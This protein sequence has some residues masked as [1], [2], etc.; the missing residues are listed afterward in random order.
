[1]PRQEDALRFAD[2]R[3]WLAS[4]SRWEYAA[5]TLWCVILLFCCIR[6]YY[7][8]TR[9]TVY[10]IY[11]SSSRLWWE[12]GELYEPYR[13][14]NEPDGYRYAPGVALLFAPFAL[15]PDAHGGVIWRMVSVATLFGA[16]GWFA[17]AVL[18]TPRTG[19]QFGAWLLLMIPLTLQSVNNGQFNVLVVAALLG[20][21]A[22]IA[23]D[24]W[25][26][27][28][29]LL[30]LAMVGKLYPAALGLVLMLLYPRRLAW[31]VPLACIA[32]VLASFVFQQPDY[33]LDQHR[34]WLASLW[35]DDRTNTIPGHMYRDLWLLIHVY[36]LPISRQAYVLLQV[37]G[38]IMVALVC[39]QRQRRGWPTAALLRSVLALTITWMMLFGP[40][41]ESSSFILLAPPLACSI[42]ASASSVLTS[43][44]VLLW[45]SGSLF[46]VAVVL[47]GLF[48]NLG[49]HEAGMHA[50][51]S[52]LYFTYLLT[53]PSPVSAGVWHL[54]PGG[55]RL[56][57]S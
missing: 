32:L 55:L 8:P 5:A 9:Q 21:V 4:R 49:V 37:V 3:R 51:A 23:Q 35:L 2:F 30:A 56:V 38:G 31:R 1:L 20:A 19:R 24:R 46:L 6:A 11:S 16:L 36:E 33:V 17:R 28:S 41:T 47:G 45:S 40:A 25:N 44:E 39:W 14:L 10:P 29:L 52:L 42:V 50:W 22:A 57:R 53:E 54:D 48:K 43:R 26:C 13:S 18:P 12:S 27:A 34:K 15:L 7:F